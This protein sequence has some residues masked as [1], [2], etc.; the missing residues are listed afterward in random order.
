MCVCVCMGMWLLGEA[1]GK[2]GGRVPPL[3]PPHVTP[4][5]GGARMSRTCVLLGRPSGPARP[6]ADAIHHARTPTWPPVVCRLQCILYRFSKHLCQ[7]PSLFCIGFGS[8]WAGIYNPSP[9]THIQT[10]PAAFT[11]ALPGTP[12]PPTHPPTHP[13][14]H[15][16]T[17]APTHL[18]THPPTHLD[19]CAQVVTDH[20]AQHRVAVQPAG[21]CDRR[22]HG[23]HNG[24][25]GRPQRQQRYD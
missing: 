1:W 8:V 23:V 6:A 11:A 24:G 5:H 4:A 9:P 25:A 16:P 10:K 14:C 21:D 19:G 15:P 3:L 17:H 12:H 20:A 18:P 22:R 2:G 13:P 7:P